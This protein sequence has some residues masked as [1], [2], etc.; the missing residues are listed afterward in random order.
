[1]MH[2]VTPTRESLNPLDVEQ[3]I[4]FRIEQA[5]GGL[6]GLIEFRSV[7][8]FGLSPVVVIF[9]DGMDIYFVRDQINERLASLEIPSGIELPQ[10]GP[11]STGLG[12]VFHYILTY[13]GIDF[14]KLPEKDRVQKLT[15]LRTL[16]DWVVK[17]LLRGVTPWDT[18][19]S[20]WSSDRVSMSR[21]SNPVAGEPIRSGLSLSVVSSNVRFFGFS[22]NAWQKMAKSASLSAT[23]PIRRIGWRAW[24]PARNSAYSGGSLGVGPLALSAFGTQFMF[25]R[26]NR[27]T[28]EIGHVVLPRYVIPSSVI[29]VKCRRA[30]S[31][32][33]IG[34]YDRVGRLAPESSA[35][36]STDPRYP[37]SDSPPASEVKNG[38]AFSPATI[39]RCSAMAEID[40]L[41]GASLYRRRT[42]FSRSCCLVVVL[43]A[44]L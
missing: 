28:V 23:V 43:I 17:P 24:I 40:R 22:L 35:C 29:G 15:E 31:W 21:T 27:N 39:S 12:E 30:N 7:S 6:P 11:V 16:H 42:M 26:Y 14:T 5:I 13:K 20:T 4:T 18:K 3:Q 41:L 36:G 10:L 2:S 32:S 37:P 33:S 25:S 44:S 1:M 38:M 34:V 8:K 9:Q 19:K